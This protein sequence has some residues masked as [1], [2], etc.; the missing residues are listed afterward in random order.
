MLVALLDEFYEIVVSVTIHAECAPLGE[1][2]IR[3]TTRHNFTTTLL[4]DGRMSGTPLL[5]LVITSHPLVE[6]SHRGCALS[7]L[8]QAHAKLLRLTIIDSIYG[9]A[10][11][12]DLVA[13]KRHHLLHTA[14]ELLLDAC[15][16]FRCQQLTVLHGCFATVNGCDVAA[17]LDHHPHTLV[18]GLLGTHLWCLDGLHRTQSVEFVVSGTGSLH[19]A[20]DT[21]QITADVSSVEC[22]QE[23]F[24][25]TLA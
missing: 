25:Q 18:L 4:V 1:L 6:L 11:L 20:V 14:L 7:E 3:I 9:A 22:C 23:S 2:L 15:N 10:C 19:N 12:S 21:A 13:Y 24:V 17:R 8:L 5:V 16:L